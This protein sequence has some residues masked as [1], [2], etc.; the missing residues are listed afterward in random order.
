[1]IDFM[2]HDQ[3]AEQIQG[4]LLELGPSVVPYIVPRLQEPDEGVRGHL[5]EVLGALGN[6]STVTVLT[7]LKNDA[8][9]DVANAAT[10]AIERIKMAQK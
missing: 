6:Q 7:P 5:A 10:H 8:N 9:R 2:D 4:Y 3:S 1:M